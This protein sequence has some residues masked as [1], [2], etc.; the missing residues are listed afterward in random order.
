MLKAFFKAAKVVE[1]TP[2]LPAKSKRLGGCT[3]GCSTLSGSHMALKATRESC[4]P[5]GLSGATTAAPLDCAQSLTTHCSCGW[6][7]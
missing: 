1:A 7:S 5:W 2:T 6:C 3:P 4:P